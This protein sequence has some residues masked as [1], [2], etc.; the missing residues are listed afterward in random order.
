MPAKLWSV[1]NRGIHLKKGSESSIETKYSKR[2][3]GVWVSGC[4]YSDS[5]G[6]Y[7]LIQPAPATLSAD[8]TRTD[9]QLRSRHFLQAQVTSS[10][11]RLTS[12]KQRFAL[13]GLVLKPSKGVIWKVLEKVSDSSSDDNNIV[14]MVLDDEVLWLPIEAGKTVACGEHWGEAHTGWFFK[15]SVQPFK[16]F[17]LVVCFLGPWGASRSCILIVLFALGALGVESKQWW[18]T[19]HNEAIPKRNV[20]LPLV[21]SPVHRRDIGNIF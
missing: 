6:N 18:R 3:L 11:L 13:N 16:E 8:T 17:P 4:Q 1:F 10:L 21:H 7:P 14:M 12:T 9:W 5:Y 15:A 19:G 20:C 2:K